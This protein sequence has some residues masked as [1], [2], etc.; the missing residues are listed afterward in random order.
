MKKLRKTFKCLILKILKSLLFPTGISK[1]VEGLRA[2]G[3]ML[4]LSLICYGGAN[5]F[6]AGFT[7][8]HRLLRF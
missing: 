1:S 6:L 2:P 4:I 5:T 7:G 3:G 8:R